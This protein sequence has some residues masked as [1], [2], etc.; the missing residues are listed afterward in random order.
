MSLIYEHWHRKNTLSYS[1]FA[2][3]EGGYYDLL[4]L[5]VGGSLYFITEMS[6]FQVFLLMSS[7][8]PKNKFIMNANK[9]LRQLW[10]FLPLLYFI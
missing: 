9:S 2:Y 3:L 8:L 7:P 4:T 6:G 5:P 10:P 1:T